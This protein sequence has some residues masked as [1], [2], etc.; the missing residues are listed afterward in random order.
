MNEG[1]ARLE[2]D[3]L[4]DSVALILERNRCQRARERCFDKHIQKINEAKYKKD[5]S[6]L[7]IYAREYRTEVS[8]LDDRIRDISQEMRRRTGK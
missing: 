1:Q 4:K 8:V 5:F 7:E 3:R 6:C 2:D